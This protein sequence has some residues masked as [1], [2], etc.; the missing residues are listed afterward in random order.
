MSAAARSSIRSVHADVPCVDCH[1]GTGAV[2]AVIYAPT[3]LREATAQLT[4]LHVA[5]G[6]LPARSCATCHPNLSKAAHPKPS[7][8][9]ECHGSVAHPV[10]DVPGPPVAVTKYGHP[11]A[12][13]Q[14]HGSSVVDAPSSCVECHKQRF[15]EACHLKETFPHPDGWINQHGKVEEAKGPIACSTCHGPTFCSSCH[16]TEIPH[17]S[18]WLGRHPTELQGKSTTPCLTCHPPTDCSTCHSEH[19]VHREQDLYTLP[20]QA[21]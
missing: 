7:D 6:V 2:S 11:Q 1:A 10:M 14:T 9:T 21:I 16:G 13:I 15:C 19:A 8:C 20:G 5:D 4:G 3:L 18:D 12:F 17:R